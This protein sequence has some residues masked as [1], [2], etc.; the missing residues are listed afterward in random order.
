MNVSIKSFLFSCGAGTDEE[1]TVIGKQGDLQRDHK[2]GRRGCP[3]G[4]LRKLGSLAREARN[5]NE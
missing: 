3:H 2:K 4:Q 1:D 5:L